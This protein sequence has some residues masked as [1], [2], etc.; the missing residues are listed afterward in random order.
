M[1]PQGSPQGLP[2]LLSPAEPQCD[3]RDATV[4]SELAAHTAQWRT[5][6]EPTAAVWLLPCAGGLLLGSGVG[7]LPPELVLPGQARLPGL[8]GKS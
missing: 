1:L 5:G 7:L 6:K 3:V 4:R 8:R 2:V